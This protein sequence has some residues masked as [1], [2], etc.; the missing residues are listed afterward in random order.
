M[1]RTG[2]GVFWFLARRWI[3]GETGVASLL[4]SPRSCGG[5]SNRCCPNTIVVPRAVGRAPICERLS[6]E[7]L[8]YC[9]LVANG[10]HYHPILVRGA[11][12][13]ATSKNGRSAVCFAVSG[14]GAY[15]STIAG[16]ESRGAGKVWMVR[17]RKRRSG[18]KKTGKNPT[19]RGKLGVKRSVLTDGRGIPLAVAIA[20]AN[21]HDQRLAEATLAGIPLP[22]PG[23]SS[24]RPQ[25]LCLD[26]GY[27]GKPIQRLARRR[28]YVLHA[29]RRGEEKKPRHKRKRARRWV[30]ERA[31][32]WTNRCRRLLVRWEK[33]AENYL[34]FIHLQFAY[35]TLRAAGVLG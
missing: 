6:T 22:R 11:Q 28:G 27:D 34:A 26:K 30:V 35:V 4:G 14:R 13:I 7:S 16:K 2:R 24:R 18:G 19:D 25:N 15:A 17:R 23:R 20:G 33:K 8:T 1:R 12:R 31:H 5:G 3:C 10:R 29:A 9:V 21:V 32:S